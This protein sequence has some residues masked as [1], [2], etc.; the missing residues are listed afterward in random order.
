MKRFTAKDGPSL[1]QT[2]VAMMKKPNPVWMNQQAEAFEVETNEGMLTGKPSDF[3]A[4]DPISGHVWP[5]A[6][7]YVI[8][9]YE[10]VPGE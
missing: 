6:A 10:P 1:Q 7:S 4:H 5:V 3:V 8:Q 9:H 2:G